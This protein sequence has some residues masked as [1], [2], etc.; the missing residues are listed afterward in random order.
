MAKLTDAH[1]EQISNMRTDEKTYAE[2]KSFFESSYKIKLWDSEIAKICKGAPAATI[3][4][5]HKR[6]KKTVTPAA[7][8]CRYL[9]I[10]RFDDNCQPEICK[11]GGA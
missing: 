7:V 10:C 1:L 5:K 2:I 3:N 8:T 6:G 11:Y 9:K 4:K